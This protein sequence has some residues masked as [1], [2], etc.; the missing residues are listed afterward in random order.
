[1]SG[2]AIS[3]DINT[4]VIRKWMLLHRNQPTASLPAFITPKASPKQPTEA[5]LIIE[6]TIARQVISVKWS[7][8]D[9]EGCA[10]FIRAA[11]Q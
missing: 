5:S 3:H 7:T 6:L 11:A 2:G 1:M 9:P 10:Q 8:L 4:N